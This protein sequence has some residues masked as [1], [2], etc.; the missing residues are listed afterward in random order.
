[1][2]LLSHSRRVRAGVTER[3]ALADDLAHMAEEAASL[4]VGLL[5][6]ELDGPLSDG[7]AEVEEDDFS[8][9]DTVPIGIKVKD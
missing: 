4:A 7:P 5:T 6:V 8:A 9:A 1:M 3:N 2:A